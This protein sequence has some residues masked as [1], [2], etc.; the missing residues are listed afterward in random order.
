MASTPPHSSVSKSLVAPDRRLLTVSR[1]APSLDIL[2]IEMDVEPSHTVR[3]ETAALPPVEPDK[4]NG[5]M[6][7][8]SKHVIRRSHGVTF[9]LPTDPEDQGAARREG[10]YPACAAKADLP[11]QEHVS[12]GPASFVLGRCLTYS[13]GMLRRFG[14][15]T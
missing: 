1:I 6:A 5:A 15:G 14:D 10:G 12:P 2:Q 13:K 4:S 11:R 8:G 9:C 7:G 3:L